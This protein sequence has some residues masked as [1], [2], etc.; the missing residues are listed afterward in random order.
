MLEQVTT[1]EETKTFYVKDG[2]N[3]NSKAS[4]KCFI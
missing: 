2:V 4:L 1:V 3:V